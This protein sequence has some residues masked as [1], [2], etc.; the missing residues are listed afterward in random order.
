MCVCVCVGDDTTGSS[1]PHAKELYSVSTGGKIKG[2]LKGLIYVLSGIYSLIEKEEKLLMNE[3]E[4][5][6]AGRK[7]EKDIWAE[8]FFLSSKMMSWNTIEGE[9]KIK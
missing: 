6:K 7:N 2:R 4:K 5:K 3:T 8:S 9:N 1:R